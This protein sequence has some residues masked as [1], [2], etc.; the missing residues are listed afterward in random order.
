MSHHL[1]TTS[2]ALLVATGLLATGTAHAAGEPVPALAFTSD[3]DGD[4]EI[5]VRSAAG[6][7]RQL[8]N[9]RASDY[10]AVWS[11]DGRRLAF[12]STR[13]G[14]R[15][16]FVMNADGSG[17]RQLTRNSKAANGAPAHDQAPAWSPD[18]SRIAFSSMRD[19]GENEIYR[20][21][22]D[23]TSQAA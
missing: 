1:R 11:P 21:N 7:V 18:G 17:L 19:G 13:D 14:D 20:M 12:V 16:I 10:G 15:E 3:R 22:A 4:A 9:N 5:V 2:A 8:T 6:A 23:G